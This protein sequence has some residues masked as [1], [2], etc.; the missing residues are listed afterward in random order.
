MFNVGAKADHGLR[1]GSHAIVVSDPL[2]EPAGRSLAAWTQSAS[3][4]TNNVDMNETNF[5]HCNEN[6]QESRNYEGRINTLA[7]EC[8]DICEILSLTQNPQSLNSLPTRGGGQ[9]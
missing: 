9:L 7:K 8:R 1:F 2:A 5:L 3:K 6:L 4:K